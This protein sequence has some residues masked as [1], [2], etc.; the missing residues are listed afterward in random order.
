ML[1]PHPKRRVFYSFHYE[2]DA[3]RT[4]QVR[5]IGALDNSAPATDNDWEQIKRGG[6]RAIQRWIDSQIAPRSCVIVLVGRHTAA[7][8]W[9]R[10]EIIKAWN[11]GKG[12]FG[13]RIDRLHDQY[14]KPSGKGPNPFSSIHLPDGAPMSKHITLHEPGWHL[15]SGQQTYQFIAQ[16]IEQWIEQTIQT[17]HR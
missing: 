7:R 9:I 3:W 11:Q 14:G 13:I 4:S 16:N 10:Y 5:N 12:L 17:R 2:D 15:N 8:K 1:A 6:D